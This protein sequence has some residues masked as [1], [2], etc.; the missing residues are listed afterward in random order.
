MFTEQKQEVATLHDTTANLGGAKFFD[1]ERRSLH[2]S[3]SALVW[4]FQSS[5]HLRGTLLKAC[6]ATGIVEP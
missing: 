6:N 4:H 5:F 2:S 3:E 1:D